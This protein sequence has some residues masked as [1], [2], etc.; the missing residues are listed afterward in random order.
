MNAEC[1]NRRSNLI[2]A[3]V[4]FIVQAFKDTD[5]LFTELKDNLDKPVEFYVYSTET[6]E[7]RVVVIMPTQVSAERG[8]SR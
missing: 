2:N 8:C 4:L 1:G 5:V 6:D 7:V 3:M